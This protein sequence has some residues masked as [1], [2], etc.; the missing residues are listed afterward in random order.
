M[1]VR[2]WYPKHNMWQQTLLAKALEPVGTV[3]STYPGDS[4]LL[5]RDEMLGKHC[6]FS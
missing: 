3:P 5:V 6:H 4:C 2:G 1:Q